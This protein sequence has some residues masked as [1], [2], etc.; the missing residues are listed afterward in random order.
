M[1]PI[2]LPAFSAITPPVSGHP[3]PQPGIDWIFGT[4]AVQFTGYSRSRTPLVART[5][6]HPFTWA[7]A[8]LEPAA[9]T[10]P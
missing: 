2:A 3:P 6:D 5:T 1:G 4:E 8:H 10:S 9:A 7:V